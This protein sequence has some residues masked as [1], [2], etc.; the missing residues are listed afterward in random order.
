MGPRPLTAKCAVALI[1]LDTSLE[2]LGG[3]AWRPLKDSK[4][5]WADVDGAAG[6]G[7]AE[8]GESTLDAA[9]QHDQLDVV[10]HSKAAG[11]APPAAAECSFK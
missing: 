11:P 10:P 5:L 7:L 2:L 3:R 9:R 6:E 8:H 1:D 4:K